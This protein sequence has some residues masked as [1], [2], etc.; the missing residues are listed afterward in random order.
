MNMQADR[1]TIRDE[2][3]VIV[4]TFE[5]SGFLDEEKIDLVGKD[6]IE[7]VRDRKKPNVALDMRNVRFCSSSIIGK[8]VAFYKTVVGLGGSLKFAAV[9]RSILEVFRVTKLDRL[10]EI[11]PT[12]EEAV[13]A[14]S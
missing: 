10:F 11:H 3:P 5:G 8:F 4:I 6:L 13:K 2:G 9:E 1:F 14:F 7:A 12:I